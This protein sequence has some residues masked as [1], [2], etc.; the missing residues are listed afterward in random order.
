MHTNENTK[1]GPLVFQSTT[2]DANNFLEPLRHA[3][4]QRC[5]VSSGISFHIFLNLVL[6]AATVAGGLGSE[7]FS[8]ISPNRFSIQFKSGDL[9]GH[10]SRG[11]RGDVMWNIIFQPLVRLPFGVRWCSIMHEGPITMAEDCPHLWKGLVQD[12]PIFLCIQRSL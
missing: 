5:N 10:F 4:A 9:A 7:T 1:I 12:I 2:L 8:D 3:M 6:S 11:S